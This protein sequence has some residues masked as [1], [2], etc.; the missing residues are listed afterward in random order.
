[1]TT[2]RRTT[3]TN[4]MT[5]PEVYPFPTFCTENTWTTRNTT[6]ST[7]LVEF[8]MVGHRRCV[9]F[10]AHT[11]IRHCNEETMYVVQRGL[12]T[13]E[14]TSHFHA[15]RVRA[16]LARKR[17]RYPH[18]L[19]FRARAD[20]FPISCTLREGA[21]VTFYYSSTFVTTRGRPRDSGGFCVVAPVEC[22]KHDF[23][24]VLMF[25]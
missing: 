18:L 11:I 22:V 10:K 9:L 5:M 8:C 2:T 6:K 23:L 1:M 12:R 25:L 15:V 24:I 16:L 21:P 20:M 14:W 4:T 13:E 3:L 7:R 17:F 19:V